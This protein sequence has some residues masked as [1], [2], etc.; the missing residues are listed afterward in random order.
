VPW[1]TARSSSLWAKK[2][3]TITMGLRR[4]SIN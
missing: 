2:D 3:A 1:R 4:I